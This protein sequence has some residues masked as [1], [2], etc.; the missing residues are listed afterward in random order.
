MANTAEITYQICD[1]LGVIKENPATGR[2]KELNLIA[3][4]G[5][6]PKYDIRDWASDHAQMGKGI[7]LTEAEAKVLKGILQQVVKIK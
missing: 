3:W 5:G 4:N 7:T 2:R 6:T 1:M